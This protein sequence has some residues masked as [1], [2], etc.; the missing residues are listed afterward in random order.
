MATI[1]SDPKYLSGL[2][3]YI[4]FVDEAGHAKDPNQRFLCLAGLLAKET[5]WRAL[6]IEWS[7]ACA[8]AAL[9]KPFHMMHL[10]AQKN[11]FKNWPESKRQDF[12]GRLLRA[13]ENAGAIPI[14]S[15]VSLE[16]YRSLSAVE[17]RG[18]KD[19]IFSRSRL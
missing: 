12:L 2:T 10:A 6:E 1:T 3:R 19:L 9:T 11:E 7:A 8:K 18:F 17:Q 14:G 13:I 15:V 5:A 4:S 16:W